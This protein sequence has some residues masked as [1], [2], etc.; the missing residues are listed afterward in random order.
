MSRRFVK[1]CGIAHG[2]TAADRGTRGNSNRIQSHPLDFCELN[3]ETVDMVQ[4]LRSD[5]A[6]YLYSAHRM[7]SFLR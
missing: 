4:S 1:R 5:N 2:G 3:D 7:A 6:T